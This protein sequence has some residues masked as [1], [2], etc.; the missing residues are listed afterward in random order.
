MALFLVGSVQGPAWVDGRPLQQQHG[1]D[2][3]ARFMN[4]LEAEGFVRLGGPVG[5]G[6][7]HRA[8]LVIDAPDP[9]TVRER[10]AADPWL[11]DGVLVISELRPWTLL[12]GE[13]PSRTSSP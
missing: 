9:A 7:P 5:D 3:H 10:L 8:L 1:W 2:E 6:L 11:R 4:A 13:L 12:L